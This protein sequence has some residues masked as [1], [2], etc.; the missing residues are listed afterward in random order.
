[1]YITTYAILILFFE[2]LFV[3]RSFRVIIILYCESAF[4]KK[5]EKLAHI[6]PPFS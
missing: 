3:R 6:F 2:A 1:M 5:A 4:L